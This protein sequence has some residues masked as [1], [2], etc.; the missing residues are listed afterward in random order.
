MVL[1][2]PDCMKT[3]PLYSLTYSALADRRP[4]PLKLYVAELLPSSAR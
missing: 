3:P 4:L 2:P 1:V